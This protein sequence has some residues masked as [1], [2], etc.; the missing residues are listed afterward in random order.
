MRSKIH[1]L[2]NFLNQYTRFP[3]IEKR[4][5][6]DHSFRNAKAV[7]PFFYYFIFFIAVLK[8][9]ELRHFPLRGNFTPRW[10][11]FWANYVDLQ[12]VLTIVLVFFAFASLV[13]AFFYYRRAGRV[14][15]FLGIFQYHALLSSFGSPH[16]QMDLWLWVAF[17]LIFLPNIWN[18]KNK[19]LEEQKKFSLVFWSAQAFVLLTYSMSGIGKI[20]GA[21]TQ[22]FN[23]E[24]H[25]FA[26]NAAALHV[27]SQLNAMQ[28]TTLL[29]PL[30]TKYP[31]FG[32]FPL[33]AIIYLQFF[34]FLIAFRP[35]LHRIWALGLVFFHVGT[36]LAMDAEFFHAIPLLLILFFNSPF[37]RLNPSWRQIAL[38]LPI[39]GWIFA[40][41]FK[42][43]KKNY[44]FEIKDVI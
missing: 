2:I 27:T 33:V 43:S 16:H 28:S 4:F 22:Y 15:A 25:I 36:F 9:L 10:P 26:L 39:F 1:H 7:V 18:E 21:I 44:L 19:S 3:V 32:W 38:D 17:L 12:I 24:V 42:R 29:G 5:E 20:L 30:I 34:A 35:S 37:G 31:L 41:I 23:G 8:L 14:I 11:I 40:S 13:A 6:E